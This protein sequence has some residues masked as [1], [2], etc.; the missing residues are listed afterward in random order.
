LTAYVEQNGG[1]PLLA[2]QDGKNIDNTRVGQDL[3]AITEQRA[4]AG[5]NGDSD[6]HGNGECYLSGSVWWNS[7]KW[8]AGSVYFDSTLGSPRYKGNWHLV[9]AYFKLNTT[10]NGKGAKDGI[11]RYW[12]DGALIIDKTDVVLR[13]GANPTMKFNQILNSPYI[14]D[15]SPVDQSFWIDNLMIATDRP[16]VPPP[17]PGK[18]AAPAPPSNLRIIR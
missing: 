2:I 16:A 6:G 18:L 7:K 1:T 15:G 12:Y 3:T 10:A 17:P 8:Y 11:M 9:E 13:T 14:G 4:V 5:C